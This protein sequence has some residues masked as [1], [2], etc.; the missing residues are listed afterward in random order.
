MIRPLFVF[1]VSCLEKN[2][3]IVQAMRR[4]V[5][6]L[7]DRSVLYTLLG[8]TLFLL[9]YEEGKFDS[10]FVRRITSRSVCTLYIE[11]LFAYKNERGDF[12]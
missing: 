1:F 2:K 9:I 10:G 5:G 11:I 6:W 3:L 12:V 4:H 7:L 8:S